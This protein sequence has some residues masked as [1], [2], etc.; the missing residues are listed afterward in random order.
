MSVLSPFNMNRLQAGVAGGDK[1]E[2]T[3]GNVMRYYSF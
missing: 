2:K 3:A 1:E